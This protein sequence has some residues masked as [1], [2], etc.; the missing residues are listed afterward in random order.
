MDRV[1]ALRTILDRA[2]RINSGYRTPAHNRAVSGGTR[3]AHLR[4]RAVDIYWLGWSQAEKDDLVRVARQLGFTGCGIGRSFVHLDDVGN[5]EGYHR[6][7]MWDYLAGGKAGNYRPWAA[8]P[9]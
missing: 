3:S 6:P 9:A 8:V 5:Q 4:G 7:L 2:I 1:Q